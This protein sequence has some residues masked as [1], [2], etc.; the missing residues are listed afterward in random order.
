MLEIVERVMIPSYQ[1]RSVQPRKLS[2]N[3]SGI[4]ILLKV[5]QLAFAIVRGQTLKLSDS[6]LGPQY[7]QHIGFVRFIVRGGLNVHF[8]LFI[9]GL[10]SAE[11]VER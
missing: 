8:P 7:V 4:S 11:I 9:R 6:S 1:I 5:A 3:I 10:C 2:E